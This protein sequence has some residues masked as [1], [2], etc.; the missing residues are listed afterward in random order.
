VDNDIAGYDV[1]FG[2]NPSPAL[3]QGN[4][5]PTVT[6][7]SVTVTTNTY[8]WKVITKDGKGNSSDSGVFKFV[9]N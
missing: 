6:T 2:A 8:Y 5:A 9:V 7:L 3:Y 4:L 1:Y